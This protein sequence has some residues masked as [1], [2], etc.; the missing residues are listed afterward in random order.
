M[1][2]I[3]RWLIW[4]VQGINW[5]FLWISKLHILFTIF[6]AN[7]FVSLFGKDKEISVFKLT[8]RLINKKSMKYF[9][10]LN[11]I[12][13]NVF[14][15]EI[16]DFLLWMTSSEEGFSQRNHW[17]NFLGYFFLKSGFEIWDECL[18]KSWISQ[19]ILENH[20]FFFFFDI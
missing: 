8:N 10:I 19:K 15:F 5:L 2:V 13:I 9:K 18:E 1:R 11:I 3:D 4:D 6:K 20:H 16:S 17:N 14:N 7:W 12:S